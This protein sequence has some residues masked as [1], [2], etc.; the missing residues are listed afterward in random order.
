VAAAV[1][2]E[3][4]KALS[5]ALA[6]NSTLEV[7]QLNRSQVGDQG[8]R[9]LAQGLRA[10]GSLRHLELSFNNIGPEGGAALAASLAPEASTGLGVCPLQRLELSHNVLCDV[11]MSL[12]EPCLSQAPFLEYLILQDCD[13]GIAGELLFYWPLLS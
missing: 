1:Q 8:A 5:G 9:C 6:S 11:G 2:K 4:A 7:L 12:M 10:N 3:G 13:V